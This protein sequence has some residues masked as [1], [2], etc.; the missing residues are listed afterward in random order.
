LN[1]AHAN[2]AH[3]MAGQMVIPPMAGGQIPEDQI[4]KVPNRVVKTE[5]YDHQQ[6]GW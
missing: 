3:Q 4:P 2:Q 5:P 1:P 6:D